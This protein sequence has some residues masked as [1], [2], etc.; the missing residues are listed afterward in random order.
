MGILAGRPLSDLPPLM[1]WKVTGTCSAHRC[2]GV[3]CH[4][5]ALPHSVSHH[6][7]AASLW[8]VGLGA[9]DDVLVVAKWTKL[10]LLGNRAALC[11]C[12]GKKGVGC[13]SCSSWRQPVL[14]RWLLVRAE[15][16]WWCDL[17]IFLFLFSSTFQE[18]CLWPSESTVSRQG[19]SE[20][21]TDFCLSSPNACFFS[22]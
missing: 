16:E 8:P 5:S 18:G 15:A 4:L 13:C 3:S 14:G 17:L 2:W 20:V 1:V 10:D 19:A 6:Q 22:L 11:S 21:L 12:L 9:V 7:L